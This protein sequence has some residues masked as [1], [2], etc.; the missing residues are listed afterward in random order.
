[1]LELAHI[2]GDHRFVVGL[3]QFLRSGNRQGAHEVLR[4]KPIGAAGADTLLLLQPDFFF[5]DEGELR[6]SQDA[7]VAVAGCH[8][9]SAI[10]GGRHGCPL[11]Q[12]LYRI[13]SE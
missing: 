3:T 13:F 4:V 11:W 12:P 10:I 9:Y 6:D 1:M 2:A 7:A 8:R 5:G